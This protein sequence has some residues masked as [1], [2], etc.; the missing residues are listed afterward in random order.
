MLYINEILK[1]NTILKIKYKYILIH[2]ATMIKS[3]KLFTQ[4]TAPMIGRGHTDK[5]SSKRWGKMNKKKFNHFYFPTNALNYTNLE[6]KI[7]VV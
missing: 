6:V 3:C 2:K 5:S 7:Y 4:V 1:N